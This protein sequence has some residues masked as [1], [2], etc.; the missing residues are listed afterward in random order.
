MSQ[1]R[2]AVCSGHDQCLSAVD[3]VLNVSYT[4][5]AKKQPVQRKYRVPGGLVIRVPLKALWVNLAF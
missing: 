4:W 5:T 2:R 1:E 3:K